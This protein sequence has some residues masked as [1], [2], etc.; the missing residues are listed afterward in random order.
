MFMSIRV[1]RRLCSCDAAFVL[2]KIE[3]VVRENFQELIVC[4]SGSCRQS[5][6]TTNEEG[7]K[8]FSMRIRVRIRNVHAMRHSWHQRSQEFWNSRDRFRTCVVYRDTPCRNYLTAIYLCNTGSCAQSCTQSF[9]CER[10]YA[11]ASWR[12]KRRQ[13]PSSQIIP[14]AAKLRTRHRP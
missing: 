5:Y 9:A 10:R 2:P 14:R 7:P 8:V 6:A 3:Y 12:L 11:T 1:A 13:N 4:N